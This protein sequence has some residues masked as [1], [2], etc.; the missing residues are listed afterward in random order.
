MVLQHTIFVQSV[1]KWPVLWNLKLHQ[2]VEDPATWS[3]QSQFNATVTLILCL[4]EIKWNTIHSSNPVL[5]KRCFLFRFYDIL[6]NTKVEGK[7]YMC[8][9][10][11]RP[12]KTY[13]GVPASRPGHFTSGA[14]TFGTHFIEAVWITELVWTLWSKEKTFATAG[15][16]IPTVELVTRRYTNWDISAQFWPIFLILKILKETYEMTLLSVCVSSPLTLMF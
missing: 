3:Y 9:I 15:N 2:R 13:G 5:P 16:R 1:M 10:E 8:L 11:R 4:S 14:K 7:L 12:M 6:L